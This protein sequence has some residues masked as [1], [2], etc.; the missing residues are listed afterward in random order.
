MSQKNV[1]ILIILFAVILS[2][3]I[4]GKLDTFSSHPTQTFKPKT[5][6]TPKPSLLPLDSP[7]SIIKEYIY[8]SPEPTPSSPP[9]SE[10][11]SF[12][13][14]E[15]LQQSLNVSLDAAGGGIPFG[16]KVKSTD[17]CDPHSPPCFCGGAEELI[18][19][20][21]PRP[22]TFAINNGTT[23]YE[24]YDWSVGNWVL[25]LANFYNDA[26]YLQVIDPYTHECVYCQS[27]GSGP[28]INIMG[29]SK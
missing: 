12:Q 2:L 21:P 16:G 7:I 4:S 8:P 20:G 3:G 22:G 11:K 27:I 9:L 6:K 13:S 28:A 18:T 15:E 1:A 23:I 24:F 17:Y 29:T 14:I 5:I 25:G 10:N 26:C 19:V